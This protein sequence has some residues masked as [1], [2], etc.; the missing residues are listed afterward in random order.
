MKQFL[1]AAFLIAVPVIA[2]STIEVTHHTESQ[3][4]DGSSHSA[5]RSLGDL[6]EYES[7]VEETR[8]L[9][10]KGD[11]TAAEKRITRFETKWDD[12]ES[13]LRP[14]APSAWGNVDAAADKA[15]AELR[16]TSPTVPRVN[17]AL[18]NLS[19]TLANP[20]NNAPGAG[21][22][23]IAGIAVTDAGGHPLPCEV[24]LRDLRDVFDQGAFSDANLKQART[25]QSQAT[26]RCNADDDVR[27]DRFSAQALALAKQSL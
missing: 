14:Q 17:Q 20:G 2:F 25:L 7:I 10:S 8:K 11:M 9:A 21:I 26:E 5:N 19:K 3:S 23:S 27:S 16:T 13:K 6:S 15:F 4:A 12:E 24:M 18:D 1:L 22:Q